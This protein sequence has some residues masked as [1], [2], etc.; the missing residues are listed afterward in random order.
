M[1]QID[2]FI[3]KLK[4]QDRRSVVEAMKLIRSH[5]ILNLRIKKLKGSENQFRARVGRYRIIYEDFKGSVKFIKVSNRD[6]NTYKF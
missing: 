2:K 3:S 1:D 5:N 4:E 6:D